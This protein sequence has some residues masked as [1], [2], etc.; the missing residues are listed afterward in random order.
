VTPAI[1]FFFIFGVVTTTVDPDPFDQYVASRVVGRSDPAVMHLAQDCGLNLSGAKVVYGVR[2]GDLFTKVPSLPKAIKQIDQ[3]NYETAEV[4]HLPNGGTI[5]RIWSMELDV[6]SESEMIACLNSEGIA[7]TVDTTDWLF[8]VEGGQ[9]WGYRREFTEDS[10]GALICRHKMF[11]DAR[12]RSIP[13]PKMDVEI[14]RNLDWTPK[15]ADFRK[16]VV[17]LR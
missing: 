7:Q 14:R 8:P 12:G 2:R 6:G 5:A 10:H 1:L 13:D 11:V 17:E 15:R 4:L 16:A 9:G 3:D